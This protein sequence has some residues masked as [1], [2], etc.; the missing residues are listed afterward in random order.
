MCLVCESE[1]DKDG[2]KKLQGLKKLCC[3]VC[4]RITSIPN[5][6]GLEEI[7]CWDCPE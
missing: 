6:Q 3:Y 4:P 2:Y 7:Y 1:K 5:I